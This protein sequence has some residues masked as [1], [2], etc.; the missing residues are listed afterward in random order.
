MTF[1]LLAALPSPEY[2][3]MVAGAITLAVLAALGTGYGPWKKRKTDVDIAE[4]Q[5]LEAAQKGSS[6]RTI[7]EL[8]DR[9]GL[10]T[11]Q[12]GVAER[13]IAASEREEAEAKAEAD[14]LRE[15][16]TDLTKTVLEKLGFLRGDRSTPE[17]TPAVPPASEAPGEPRVSEGA[18]RR[19]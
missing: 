3:G 5:R 6:V 19:G 15:I 14:R 13:R 10:L 7:Q 11:D 17:A 1:H 18:D 16:A 8:T 4:F 9:I 12:L 2:W